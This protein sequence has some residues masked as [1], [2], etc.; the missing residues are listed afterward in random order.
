MLMPIKL[1]KRI[2]ISGI[3]KFKILYIYA[4]FASNTLLFKI[5]YIYIYENNI[6]MCSLKY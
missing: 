4:Y 6:N 2:L 1:I 5:V 3:M